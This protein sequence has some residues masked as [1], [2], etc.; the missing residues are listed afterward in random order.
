[1][2]RNPLRQNL[3]DT[4]KKITNSNSSISRKTTP[5]AFTLATNA[6]NTVTNELLPSQRDAVSSTP[7]LVPSR[8][9]PVPTA[10]AFVAQVGEGDP[11]VNFNVGRRGTLRAGTN[12]TSVTNIARHE[13][14]HL[15]GANHPAIF[16][17]GSA[18]GGARSAVGKGSSANLTNAAQTQG[19]VKLQGN[20]SLRSHRIFSRQVRQGNNQI[21]GKSGGGF[22]RRGTISPN[23]IRTG[24]QSDNA[25]RRKDAR[26][27]SNKMQFRL[28]KAGRDF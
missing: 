3:I 19:A 14:A 24:L 25:K 20:T 2:P 22:K 1:M 28:R 21:P 18:A 13:T 23:P 10:V 7:N 9:S 16:A 8:L 12:Q 11:T 4:R 26:A 6:L 17:A 5:D 27:L 15:L